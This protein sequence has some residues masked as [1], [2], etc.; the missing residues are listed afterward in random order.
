MEGFLLDAGFEIVV[1]PITQLTERGVPADF[2]YLDTATNKIFGFQFKALYK[3]GHDH[4]NLEQAQHRS[5]A[6]F[7]WMYYG[8]SDLKTSRQHRKLESRLVVEIR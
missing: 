1:L 7:D 8:L 4:W 5:L 3:N 6:S 2:L